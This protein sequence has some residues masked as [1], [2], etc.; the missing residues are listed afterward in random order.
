MYSENLQS[1]G[2]KTAKRLGKC[3]YLSVVILWSRTS[4]GGW[5]LYLTSYFFNPLPHT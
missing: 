4:H 2:T 5:E 1:V 3:C